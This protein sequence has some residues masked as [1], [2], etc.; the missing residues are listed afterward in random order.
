VFLGQ[1]VAISAIT[2]AEMNNAVFISLQ[3]ML[4][5]TCKRS[6]HKLIGHRG[7][8]AVHFVRLNTE[9]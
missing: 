8:R 4:L 9:L 7:E 1:G 2:S 6:M 3:G 5:L